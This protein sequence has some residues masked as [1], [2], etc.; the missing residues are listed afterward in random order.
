MLE[1]HFEETNSDFADRRADDNDETYPQSEGS[2]QDD[3]TQILNETSVDEHGRVCFYGS[4]SLFHTQVGQDVLGRQDVIGESVATVQSLTASDCDSVLHNGALQQNS[5]APLS[6]NVE[7]EGGSSLNEEYGSSLCQELLETYWCW[8][9]HLHLVLC[10]RLFM[11][12]CKAG[13][14]AGL[15]INV[16][17]R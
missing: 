17:D 16:S 4:T 8:P 14:L 13:L 9:H 1:E 2:E 11:R 15:V 6:A 10:R 12:K 7:P 3:I 5:T